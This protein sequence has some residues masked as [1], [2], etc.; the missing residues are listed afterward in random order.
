MAKF[1]FLIFLS[2][3]TVTAEA[4]SLEII[5]AKRN[6][7]LS[8]TDPVYKD[9]YISGGKS[10]GLK[11]NSLVK[12]MRKLTI[13]DSSLKPIG[14]V[15][16][17]VAYI[18]IIH[19]DDKISIGREEKFIPRNDEAMLEQIGIMIGDTIEVSE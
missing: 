3:L 18:K 8:D 7:P 15:I 11:K 1:Y 9:F 10:S 4:A 19:V 13:K 14:D 16:T 5:E 2:V 12:V 17:P 6:I